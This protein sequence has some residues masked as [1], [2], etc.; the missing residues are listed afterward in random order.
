MPD[1]GAELRHQDGV[2]NMLAVPSQ[3]KV[4]SVDGGNRDMEHV[5]S[6][7]L[8]QPARW[9]DMPRYPRAFRRHIE[10]GNLLYHCQPVLGDFG[11]SSLNLIKDQLRHVQ[12]E[13]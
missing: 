1:R 9:Q 8:R 2:G 10:T 13:L 3:K 7:D 6:R 11:V 4:D 12:I 5:A